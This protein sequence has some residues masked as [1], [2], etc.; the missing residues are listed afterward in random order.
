MKIV[1]VSS[2]LS[3]NVGNR[4]DSLRQNGIYIFNEPDAPE[5]F[6]VNLEQGWLT[7]T[8]LDE[9]VPLES[10]EECLVFV[11]SRCAGLKDAIPHEFVDKWSNDKVKAYAFSHDLKSYLYVALEK[12]LAESDVNV[13][14]LWN[15][16]QEAIRKGEEEIKKKAGVIKLFLIKHRVAHLWLPLDIDLQGIQEVRNGKSEV[17]GKKPEERAVE[18][19][20][21]VL[22]DKNGDIPQYYRQKLA[23]LQYAAAGERVDFSEA[24]GSIKC[25][26]GEIEEC[27]PVS[28]QGTENLLG[29][30]KSIYDLILESK[31]K[32]DILRSQEWTN[33]LTLCGL[34]KDG[35]GNDF[36]PI[37]FQRSPILY[38]MC[39]M[40]GMISNPGSRDVT[41]VLDPFDNWEVKN[42]NP[43][44]IKSFHDWFCALDDCLDKL[45]GKL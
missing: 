18:Y 23:K 26:N 6:S 12:E 8:V 37:G 30:D 45:R 9:D 3:K 34:E 5:G 28:P 17:G 38:F 35:T 10:D 19:L 7:L 15:A 22:Q 1:I 31:K 41:E 16:V 20:K 39:L 11:H 43:E 24:N 14:S 32:T 36:R 40:D 42:A 27:N 25:K 13:M 33:L 44:R 4:I 21:E 29:D 2:P